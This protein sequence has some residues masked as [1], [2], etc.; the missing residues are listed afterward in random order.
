MTFSYVIKTGKCIDENRTLMLQDFS[1]KGISNHNFN[2]MNL[3]ITMEPLKYGEVILSNSIENDLIIRYIVV[4]GDKTYQIDVCNEGM[5]NKVTILGKINLSWIDSKLNINDNETF[6]REIGKSTIYFLD[7]EII[8]RK[9]ELPANPFKKLQKDSKL[10]NNF[11]T[12]DIET[13]KI[14]NKITPYLINAYDGRQHITSYN[15]NEN[16]LFKE[17]MD[18][19]LKNLEKGSRTYIYAHNLSTFDGVLILKHLFNYGETKP[20][21]HNGKIIS[22]KLII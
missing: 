14:D 20:L 9:K 3:P 22:I 1:N 17:F 18:N 11:I 13:I 15:K 2:N 16:L 6:K 12:M 5:V 19:L 4:N 21:L 8:L 10:S 7:G